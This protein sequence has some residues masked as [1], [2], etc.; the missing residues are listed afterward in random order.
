MD[1]KLREEVKGIED[2]NRVDEV[3]KLLGLCW[4]PTLMLTLY[5]AEESLEVE[6]YRGR[7]TACGD[8]WKDNG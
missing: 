3:G 4:T 7:E 1:F 2:G 5:N 8:M 6:V